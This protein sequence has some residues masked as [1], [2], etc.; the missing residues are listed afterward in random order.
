MAMGLKA[1]G[2]R[3]GAPGAAQERSVQEPCSVFTEEA[4]PLF[5]GSS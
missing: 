1:S 5:P 2:P 4:A 3:Q